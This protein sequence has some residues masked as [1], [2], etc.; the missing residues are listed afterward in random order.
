MI[1]LPNGTLTEEAVQQI[2]DKSGIVQVLV[3]EGTNAQIVLV[4]AD[5]LGAN[6]RMFDMS[7]TAAATTDA[8]RPKGAPKNSV[9]VTPQDKNGA[10]GL[11]LGHIVT[12]QQLAEAGLTADSLRVFRIEGNFIVNGGKVTPNDD[13]SVVVWIEHGASFV[14]VN[15]GK[16]G[17]I[18]GDGS[19]PSM[20][21]ALQV[22]RLLVKLSNTIEGNAIALEAVNVT[23]IGEPDVKAPV[24]ADALQ[25]LRF[26]V[27][28]SS[29][30]LDKVWK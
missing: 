26:L 9:L 2:R 22:L 7:I 15:Q 14:L 21:D 20:Y 28:L 18:S 17:N 19:Q 1:T 3:G 6:P 5:T 12:S 27:K 8:T 10:F 23:R 4:N 13:G 24:M 16:L 11:E 30:E 29:P 25:I